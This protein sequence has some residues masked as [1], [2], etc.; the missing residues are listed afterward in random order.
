MDEN[1]DEEKAGH[2][3]KESMQSLSS[4]RAENESTRVVVKAMSDPAVSPGFVPEGTAEA[5]GEPVDTNDS[6]AWEVQMNAREEKETNVSEAFN[7]WTTTREASKENVAVMKDMG[8]PLQ[9]REEVGEK[10]DIPQSNSCQYVTED[11][12]DEKK[13]RSL[14]ARSL[15]EEYTKR[16]EKEQRVLKARSLDEESV[17]RFDTSVSDVSAYGVVPEVIPENTYESLQENRQA[18]EQDEV[19]TMDFSDEDERA[20]EDMRAH[21]HVVSVDVHEIPTLHESDDVGNAETLKESEREKIILDRSSPVVTTADVADKEDKNATEKTNLTLQDVE[22]PVQKVEIG[23]EETSAI[24]TQD[25]VENSDAEGLSEKLQRTIGAIKTAVM[26]HDETKLE[27]LECSEDLKSVA[28]EADFPSDIYEHA[29]DDTDAGIGETNDGDDSRAS[30]K[31]G[32]EK[33]RIHDAAIIAEASDDK[34]DPEVA[35]GE[36]GDKYRER[37]AADAKEDRKANNGGKKDSLKTDSSESFDLSAAGAE[38]ND[39]GSRNVKENTNHKVTE[40]VE[41]S[42]RTEGGATRD[43][44]RSTRIFQKTVKRTE[45]TRTVRRTYTKWIRDETRQRARQET[46]DED[47]ATEPVEET[48]VAPQQ[49][50]P[51]MSIPRR[52][53]CPMP[54]SSPGNVCSVAVQAFP[55]VVDQGVQVEFHEPDCITRLVELQIAMNEQEEV[56]RQDM[57][58]ACELVQKLEAMQLS[59]SLMRTQLRAMDAERR[60]QRGQ[61]LREQMLV[62]QESCD[63]GLLMVDV[64]GRADKEVRTPDGGQQSLSS[65]SPYKGIRLDN[66]SPVYLD[67][68]SQH[69]RLS[70]LVSSQLEAT[71]NRIAQLRREAATNRPRRSTIDDYVQDLAVHSPDDLIRRPDASP[72]ESASGT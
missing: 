27:A 17:K 33:G 60:E 44:V 66:S 49:A 1:S 65:S 57:K 7:D 15:D 14:K 2:N 23:T 70:A 10:Q 58:A 30:K 51:A 62:L 38:D 63:N 39:S 46:R 29:D 64:L 40:A 3:S 24:T 6:L 55:S 26:V 48:L 56:R 22:A 71:A 50:F 34:V 18:L 25:H 68:L 67:Q 5:I 19:A 4:A 11:T 20:L 36:R 47:D 42:E 43:Q 69:R 28:T 8:V 72:S 16:H 31:K 53:L 32:E 9:S 41:Q 35:E 54:E 12:S 52:G 37:N 21:E 45:S 59:E 61:R 13:P